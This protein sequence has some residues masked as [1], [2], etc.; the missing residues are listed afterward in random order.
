MLCP[1]TKLRVVLKGCAQLAAEKGMIFG[2]VWR[3]HMNLQ[4]FNG[5]DCQACT[6]SDWVS[7]WT[8]VL[9]CQVT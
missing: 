4:T 8:V 9:S 2:T 7:R 5:L 3:G 6:L 1:N